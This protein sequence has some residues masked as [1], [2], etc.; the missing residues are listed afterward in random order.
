MG[1][2]SANQPT[3]RAAYRSREVAAMLGISN[4][5]WRKLWVQ[6]DAPGPDV[7]IRNLHLWR[8][9]TIDD[10]LAAR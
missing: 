2:A 5:H 8:K 6:G 3:E 7:K 1:A 9:A 4:P 10:W